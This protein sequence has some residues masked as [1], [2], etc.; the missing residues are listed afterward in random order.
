MN[1]DWWSPITCYAVTWSC[2]VPKKYFDL[3]LAYD[4]YIVRYRN[5]DIES[6]ETTNVLGRSKFAGT[7]K[8]FWRDY[9]WGVV[10]VSLKSIMQDAET[11]TWGLDRESVR[12]QYFRE[13]HENLAI[14]I[15]G[16]AGW[17]AAIYPI[18]K[19]SHT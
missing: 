7:D 14:A 10:D 6:P 12:Y 1:P 18:S 3:L 5:N 2:H 16:R 19:L 17:V 9:E 11:I 13:L 4:I 8:I 15:H